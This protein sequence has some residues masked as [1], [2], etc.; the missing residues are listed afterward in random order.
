MQLKS[1]AELFLIEPDWPAPSNVRSFV[2]TRKGGI[3]TVPY[4]TLNLGDRVGD[5]F[6]AVSF[7]RQL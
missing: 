7:N 4:D 6:E 5:Q 2:T 3:S 1:H